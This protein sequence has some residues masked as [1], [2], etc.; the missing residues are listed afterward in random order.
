MSNLKDSY[1]VVIIGG[2]P[3]GLISSILLSLQGIPHMLFERYSGTSIHPKAVGI[4]QRTS[5]IL[6]KIGVED[7][8]RRQAAPPEMSGRTAW[9]TSLGKSG[10][11]KGWA[12]REIASRYAWGAGPQYAPN[13]E[14][15]SPARYF[16]LPQIRLEPILKRRAEELNPEGIWFGYDVVGVE[17]KN[18]H[19]IL[20]VQKQKCEGQ[21]LKFEA[22]W[23]I[24]ADGGRGLAN[25]MG[26]RWNGESDVIDMVSAH[27]RAPIS[28]YHPDR[29][30][31]ISWFVNPEMGGSINTGYLYHLGPYPIQQDTEEWC[32][33]CAFLPHERGRTFGKKEMRER[34]KDVLKLEGLDEETEILSLSTWH[35]NA[36]VVERYR[37]NGGR[38]FFVGDAAHRIPPWGALGMNSG[39]QDA[40]NLVWKLALAIKR[41]DKNW[42][43]LLD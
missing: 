4:N 3:V 37:S 26:M 17:E 23:V 14:K 27:I 13:F 2:G 8:V 29:S 43:G 30:I 42:N 41:A 35:V 11:G 25:K 33:A 19:V 28:K 10:L 15:A 7:E 16:L 36:K 38:V 9:Y 31:F 20:A 1:P 40:D 21:G 34:M 5:E 18:D 6:R 22:T 32:F 12:G 24:G 39:A